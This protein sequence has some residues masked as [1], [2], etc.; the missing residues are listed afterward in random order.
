MWCCFEV[1]KDVYNLEFDPNSKQFFPVKK[2]MDPDA[3]NKEKKQ[4]Y[5]ELNDNSKQILRNYFVP[6]NE[7]LATLLGKKFDGWD[8]A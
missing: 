7:K 8:Y 4:Y 5:T 6:L 2:M 1:V 3:S